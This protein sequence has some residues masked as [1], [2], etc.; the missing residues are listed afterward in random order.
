MYTICAFKCRPTNQGIG[1]KIVLECGSLPKIFPF[2]VCK[3]LPCISGVGRRWPVSA[4]Y[5]FN[6]SCPNKNKSTSEFH[7]YV[8]HGCGSFLPLF[9]KPLECIKQELQKFRDV[10]ATESSH[11][12]ILP[13][14]W[15]GL[16]C[17]HKNF[18]MMFQLKRL[19]CYHIDKNA[20]TPT[21]RQYWKQYHFATLRGW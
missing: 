3:R 2:P 20:D 11:F 17:S 8:F 14:F 5:Y 9:Y 16:S 13:I 7:V 15:P 10:K 12:R 1:V 6:W 18:M 19:K 21:N 4:C